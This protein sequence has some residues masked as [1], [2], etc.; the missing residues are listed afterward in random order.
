M[1][2]PNVWLFTIPFLYFG[3]RSLMAIENIPG[4][5]CFIITDPGIV[6]AGLLSVLTNKFDQKIDQV[7]EKTL[8][9]GSSILSPR[10]ASREQYK[11]ILQYAFEGKHIDF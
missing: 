4:K 11:K 10:P 2:E 6:K 5:K 3:N 1:D 7:I 9:S 8:E